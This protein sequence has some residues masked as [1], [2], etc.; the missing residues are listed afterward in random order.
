[1]SVSVPPGSVPN[2]ILVL[3]TQKLGGTR[4]RILDLSLLDRETDREMGFVF[5]SGVGFRSALHHFSSR[6]GLEALG[7]AWPENDRKFAKFSL[8][9]QAECHSV[10]QRWQ[11]GLIVSQDECGSL[12]EE[13]GV[14]SGSHDPKPYK[15]RGFGGIDG[16]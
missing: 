5:F 4:D 16:P 1:M 15:S 8:V 3:H 10:S 2:S 9:S 13:L 6:P 11:V 14:T 7:Q 12:S